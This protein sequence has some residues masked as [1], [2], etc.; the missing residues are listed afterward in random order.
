MAKPTT[1]NSYCDRYMEGCERV[2]VSQLEA[3]CRHLI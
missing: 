1:F 2:V 3:G